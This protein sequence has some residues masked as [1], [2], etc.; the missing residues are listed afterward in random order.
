MSGCT[1]AWEGWQGTHQKG[2]LFS[3]GVRQTHLSRSTAVSRRSWEGSDTAAAAAFL[4]VPELASPPLRRSGVQTEAC[5]TSINEP[6]E[7]V[8]LMPSGCSQCRL[9]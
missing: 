8:L 7:V 3:R 9:A 2:W 5:A 6:M 4:E 1:R